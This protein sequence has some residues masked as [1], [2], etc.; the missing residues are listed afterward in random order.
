MR[1]FE[2]VM[3]KMDDRQTK[4][5]HRVYNYP[6]TIAS[7]QDFIF[8]KL[9][10]GQKADFVDLFSKWKTAFTPS[11]LSWPPRTTQPSKIGHHPRRR[12]Q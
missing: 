12:N 6:Y 5:V 10:N 7:Q 8:S 2:R 4:V 3:Q 1:T 11:P 9:E